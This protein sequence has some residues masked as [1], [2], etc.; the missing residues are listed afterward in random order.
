MSASYTL[1]Q[2]SDVHLRPDGV[3]ANGARPRENLLAALAAVAEAVPAPDAFLLT[4]DL[5]DGGDAACYDDLAELARAAAGGAE[6]IY[7]PGNHDERAAFRRHL[8][9]TGG[10][11]PVN[12]ARRV[13]GLRVIALDSVI[14]GEDRGELGEEALEFLRREL[15]AGPAPDG[16]VVALH[17]PPVGSPIEPMTAIALGNPRQLAQAV[18]GSDVRLIMA[19]HFHHEASGQLG[20]VP[21]WVGPATAYRLDTASTGS[22]QNIHAAAT[23]R[24]ELT[25][26]GPLATTIWAR[27]PSGR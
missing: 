6:V 11:G 25:P 23:S 16:T 7:L 17:H 24:I 5:T 1:V 22:Y 10:D 12:Q 19:G 18:A 20:G 8:L 14:P 26:A 9:G 15:A 13:G 21:V 2:V 3:M 27:P 4:G